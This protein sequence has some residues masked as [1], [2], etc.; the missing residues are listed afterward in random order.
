MFLH[1]DAEHYEWKYTL[2]SMC[3]SRN[4]QFR[5]T[6]ITMCNGGRRSFTGIDRW[7]EN[8]ISTYEFLRQLDLQRNMSCDN[9]MTQEAF[10][11]CFG[12]VKFMMAS[13]FSSRMVDGNM[14][15]ILFAYIALMQCL[16]NMHMGRSCLWKKES[17]QIEEQQQANTCLEAQVG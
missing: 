16:I 1:I 2:L 9:G 11:G 10:F 8:R 6:T 17:N 13:I 12:E 3:D 4:T 14:A 5:W 7:C 15:G